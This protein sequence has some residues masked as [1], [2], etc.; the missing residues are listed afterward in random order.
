MQEFKLPKLFNWQTAS[1]KLVKKYV[2]DLFQTNADAPVA[3][4]L[5]NNTGIAFTYEYV[6][7]G[8]YSV[9]ANQPIFSGCTMGC[10][11]GQ[12]NQVTISNSFNYVILISAL[13]FP[14]TDDTMLIF[15]DDSVGAA[16]D[17]L[18]AYAQNT[19]ELTIYPN[20]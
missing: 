16:D 8:T 12:K 14:V 18:G 20:I 1:D 9:T 7:P 5:F 13:V 6:S 19:I 2:A 10:P 3:T 17:I 11:S 15:T 4:E